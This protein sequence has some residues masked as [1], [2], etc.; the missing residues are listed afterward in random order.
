MAS[1][2]PYNYVVIV[3]T[4]GGSKASDIMLA[5][6]RGPRIGK[7]WFLAGSILPNEE[8]VDVAV[9]WSHKETG[10]TLTC[11][12]LTLLSKNPVRV[13]LP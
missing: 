1:F 4:F 2:G 3:M 10:L 9:R 11:D 5:S 8:H 6:Q 12:D 7:T 13:S